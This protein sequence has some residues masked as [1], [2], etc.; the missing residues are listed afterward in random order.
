MG[1]YKQ[2]TL[3]LQSATADKDYRTELQTIVDWGLS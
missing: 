2:Q 1:A 3:V